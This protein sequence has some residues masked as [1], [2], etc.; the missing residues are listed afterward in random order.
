MR[1]PNSSAESSPVNKRSEIYRFRIDNWISETDAN[2]LL[3]RQAEVAM[4]RKDYDTALSLY[5][6]LIQYEP[7]SAEHYNNRGLICYITKQWAKAEAD[8]NRAI[9]L[10][11]KQACT[12]NNRA[13]LYA[14]RKAWADAIADYDTAIDLNPL[15]MRARL[16]Q[17]ITFREIGEYQESLACLDIALLLVGSTDKSNFLCASICA[18]R[19]RTYHIQGCWNCALADYRR[20]LS[21]SDNEAVTRRVTRWRNALTSECGQLSH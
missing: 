9:A 8:Y 11:P 12:Y 3:K 10:D 16:N 13:N 20:A 15:N 1:F 4:R 18:E 5:E 19:G 21:L 17:A 14:V 6:R 7:D 2:L